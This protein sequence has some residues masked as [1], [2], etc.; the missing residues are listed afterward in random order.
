MTSSEQN[1]EAETQETGGGKGGRRMR[2]RLRKKLP[3]ESDDTVFL[4]AR[5]EMYGKCREGRP[6]TPKN[7]FL[8]PIWS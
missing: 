7:P 5:P 2:L 4:M 1:V 3:F 6:V 8:K